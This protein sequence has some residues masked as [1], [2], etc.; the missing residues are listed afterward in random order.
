MIDMSKAFNRVDH[1]LV[2]ED[3]FLMKCP[4]W[5][6][7]II[8]SYLTGRSIIVTFLGASTGLES[9]P[10]S[11]PQGTVLGVIIFL[12]KFNGA[13]LRP[14]IPR[15]TM[16]PIHDSKST[17]SKFMDDATVAVTV[18]LKT[19]LVPDPTTRPK[20]LNYHEQNSLILPNEQNLLTLYLK[21]LVKFSED[22]KM[23]I[24]KEKTKIMTF[25]FSRNYNFPPEIG[26]PNN[27]HFEV[28][29]KMRV[30]GV[31]LSDDLQWNENTDNMCTKARQRLW[32]II[33]LKNY[34][35]KFFLPGQSPGRFQA[36]LF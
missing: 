7:R 14:K 32:V 13:C 27:E 5:I 28:V 4:A 10:G 16:G 17:S 22:N 19:S 6:L 20:P 2:I 29:R 31:I 26:L 33:R 3:L 11:S 18:N 8:F 36:V 34:S 25:N 15:T 12:V 9:L 23:K 1:N 24:K 30:L 21:D 35:F